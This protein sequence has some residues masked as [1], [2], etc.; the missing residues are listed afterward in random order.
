MTCDDADVN[1]VPKKDVGFA[2]SRLLQGVLIVLLVFLAYF[3]ALCGQF[4]WDD[5]ANVTDNV[6]LRSLAG[7][8]RIW[9]ELGATQQYYPLTHTSFWAE[10]H[11]WGLSP[12][13]YHVTN[14]CFHALNAI[15]LWL[16]LRR[17]GV[18]G[19]WLGAAIFA[20]HPVQVESVAWIT[21]RKNTLSGVFYLGSI[22]ASVKFWLPDPASSSS[23]VTPAQVSN[24]NHG[25]WRYYLVGLALYLFA[26]WS[27]TAT[28]ALPAVIL[29]LLWWKCGKIERRN[30]YLLLPFLIIGFV[31]GMI[32][33][34]VEKNHV[35]AA[36]Q[37]WNF[38]LVERCLITGRMFWFY[39][40]KL[41]WP[42]PLMFI[43]P[44][45]EIHASQPAAY[46]PVLAAGI[47]LLILWQNRNGW[48]RPALCAA[49]CF[50]ATLF[51]VLGFF[52][53]FFFRFSFVCDHFQYLAS[54][55]PL[56]LAAAGITVAFVPFREGKPFMEPV[57]G[58]MLLLVLGGLT[59][60]QAAVYRNSETLWRDTL[61][62]NPDS[63]IAHDNLGSGLLETGRLD[64]AMDHF[65]KSIELNPNGVVAHNDYS[66]ALR[67]RGRLDDAKLEACKALALAPNLV[68]P[69]INL[70]K[71]LRQR[72][73]LNEAVTEYKNI[74]QLV[75]ASEPA[76][77]GLAD[78]LC[79]LGRSDEAISCYHEILGANPNNTDVRTKLGLVLIEKGRFTAAESEFSSVLQA[80][81]RN[82]KAFDGLGYMLAMQGRLDEAKNRFFESMQNDPKYAYP[83]LHYAMSLSAQ[84]QASEAMV[85][86]RKALALDD[87]L[88]PACNNLAWML[89]SHP[90]PQIRNGKEAVD[91]AERACRLTNNEQPVYLGTLAA[92]YAE[93]GRF[94]DAIATAEK[95]RDLAR[96]AGLEKVAERNEQLLEFYRAG[97]PYHEPADAN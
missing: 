81:P 1:S 7:L 5:D 23:N 82:A 6:P 89:A 26:L 87:Q 63:W 69:H 12:L 58:A 57:F 50:I 3:P 54:I 8:R 84:R 61:A 85:E 10:Y 33:M 56:A 41:L 25:P 2:S 20:L 34:W 9:F 42:Y 92:A 17:L 38:S 96:K 66:V 52:N 31:M 94:S 60:R 32:T 95:A 36:G 21:E 51:P 76:R 47:G 44:R 29:L 68:E 40:G 88:S 70:V 77:I 46:L 49:G 39:L 35:G 45:W 72:G 74:L 27:K 91:L 86:Y 83:H 22:L 30:I 67:Q 16:I 90:D 48:G 64:E 4:L 55:G 97:R 93:A 24:V 19:A 71:I 78:T 73:E 11:L 18:K 37:E 13:G 14:V 75:P 28:V 65:R 59:W 62:K 79:L 43:Y 80:D 53:V 15:L